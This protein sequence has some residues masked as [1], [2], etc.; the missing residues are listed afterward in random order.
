MFRF[1][2][3]Y[4]GPKQTRSDS[5]QD[6]SEIIPP[7]LPQSHVQ[8]VDKILG[9]VQIPAIYRVVSVFFH[10]NILEIRATA[11]ANFYAPQ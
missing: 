5:D 7:A 8:D 9:S 11:N 6:E 10:Q 2:K 1:L 4:L 3:H